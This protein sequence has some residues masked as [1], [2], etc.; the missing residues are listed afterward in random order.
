MTTQMIVIR[1]LCFIVLVLMFDAAYGYT[2]TEN[3]ISDSSLSTLWSFLAIGSLA[4][5]IIGIIKGYG[6]NRSIIIF[7]NYDD[8]GLT[9]LLPASNVLIF[10]IGSMLAIRPSFLAALCAATTIYLFAILVRNT[11]IDNGRNV[12]NTSLAMLTKLPLA[13]IWIL[14]LLEILNPSG[15]GTQRSRNR[16]QSL[17]ILTLLTPIIGMLVV[18]KSGSYFNPVDWI[19]NRRVGPGIR[20]HL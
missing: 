10:Y 14:N 15:K 17:I 18:D 16:G 7:R 20:G 12:F 6:A 5:L 19:R 9:F 1:R 13:V 4:V 8:L 2:T 11:F 3:Q